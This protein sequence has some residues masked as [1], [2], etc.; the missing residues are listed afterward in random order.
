MADIFVSY[1]RADKARVAPLVEALEAAGWSVWWD[2]EISGGQAFD[3]LIEEQLTLASCVVVV[4]SATSVASRWVKGEARTAAERG[5]LLPVQIDKARPPIDMRAIHTIDLVAKG[6]T[7]SGA[8]D[9]LKHSVKRLAGEPG[10][11]LD[12]VEAVRARAAIREQIKQ[13]FSSYRRM[14]SVGATMLSAVLATF[15]AAL[16]NLGQD[17]ERSALFNLNVWVNQ[18]FSLF[19]HGGVPLFV[20]ILMVTIFLSPLG[21]YVHAKTRSRVATTIAMFMG[22]M[23]L[24]GVLPPDRSLE[25]SPVDR[26]PLPDRVDMSRSGGQ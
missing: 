12:T 11:A 2:T 21:F 25:L 9:E 20:V 16:V 15:V 23:T 22:V 24:A 8:M 18:G 26:V 3:D 10:G 4:W 13:T 6:S 14:A 17:N 5:V 1:A 19:G 7:N